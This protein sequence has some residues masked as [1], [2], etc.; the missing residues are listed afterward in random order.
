MTPDRDHL[1]DFARRYTAAWC[2]Q[3]PS[4][5]AEHYA[6]AGSLTTNDGSPAVGRAAITE[7][8]LGFMSALPDIEAVMDDL[9]VQDSGIEF[10]WTS[11]V[12]TRGQAGPGTAFE[13]A[14]SR[15]GR[16]MTT[17]SSPSHKATTTRPSTNASSSTA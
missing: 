15:S 12:P 4:S 2:S 14:D 5:V 9:L 8:A 6:S 3:D 1:I 7:A 13:S 10:H 16:S 11:P 17:G